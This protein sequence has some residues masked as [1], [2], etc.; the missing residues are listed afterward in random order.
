MNPSYLPVHTHVL[1]WI[2]AN[3][4]TKI[5][6][7]I[8]GLNHAAHF[9]GN[10]TTKAGTI[11]ITVYAKS[12]QIFTDHD[13]QVL[14]RLCISRGLFLLTEGLAYTH[15]P[16]T[17]YLS[18][19]SSD[20]RPE[21]T[22]QLYCG[23][24]NTELLPGQDIWTPCFACVLSR[25][26]LRNIIIPNAG[27][28]ILSENQHLPIDLNR[29][30][31][32]VLRDLVVY[33]APKQYLYASEIDPIHYPVHA[34]VLNHLE[35]GYEIS[36]DSEQGIANTYHIRY[37][38][39]RIQITIAASRDLSRYD[40][41]CSYF[42]KKT[43]IETIL[44][45]PRGLFLLSQGLDYH[46]VPIGYRANI[47]CGSC[48]CNVIAKYDYEK[49]SSEEEDYNPF[50]EHQCFTCIQAR[51]ELHKRIIPATVVWM[52]A[53]SGMI[54]DVK[55]SILETLCALIISLPQDIYEISPLHQHVHNRLLRWIANN[56]SYTLHTQP[57]NPHVVAS[58]TSNLGEVLTIC[59]TTSP[60]SY[61][62]HYR[63]DVLRCPPKFIADKFFLAS[64]AVYEANCAGNMYCGLCGTTYLTRQ[65]T[66]NC[67]VCVQAR[68]KFAEE[69]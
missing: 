13:D 36:I 11:E 2:K 59:A 22:E 54:N 25:R 30:V 49:N 69:G 16:I 12:Y 48:G 56:A 28:W 4:C 55:R 24:C 10:F 51:N 60:P 43:G 3:K 27:L 39:G 40:I 17:V 26:E 37:K 68:C 41:S 46:V 21:F 38:K 6:E 1:A 29:Q 53:H 45:I 61:H 15:T 18:D 23:S 44:Q 67:V 42:V 8:P 7:T 5:P 63:H 57:C 47:H 32:G 19:D 20:E 64:G 50:T 33:G 14:P 34:Y 31:L 9:Y 62:I 35:N 58:Y 52:L 65:E 66:L